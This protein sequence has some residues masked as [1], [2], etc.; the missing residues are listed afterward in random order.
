MRRHVLRVIAWT[1]IV[2]LAV[3]FI[4]GTAGSFEPG[5]WKAVG[6][7]PACLAELAAL[8]DRIWWTTVPMLL[9]FASGYVVIGVAAIREW[10]RSRHPPASL[11]GDTA[12]G[13]GEKDRA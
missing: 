7:P 6:A 2:A 9:V 11:E 5:C 8:N 3:L 1:V 10:R 4:P 13:D 12:T